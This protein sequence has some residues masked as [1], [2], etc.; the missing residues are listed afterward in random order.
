M[1]QP[2]SVYVGEQAS[3]TYLIPYMCARA[4]TH[5]DAP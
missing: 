2:L 4:H 3:K 5:L 1:S